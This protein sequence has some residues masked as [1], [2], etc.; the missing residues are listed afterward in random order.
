M[1][2]FIVYIYSA[3]LFKSSN[4]LQVLFLKKKENIPPIFWLPYNHHG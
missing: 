3:V 4:K 2:Y 1:H